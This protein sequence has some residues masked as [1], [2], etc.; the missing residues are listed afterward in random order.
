[1]NVVLTES[2]S[3]WTH[4][5]TFICLCCLRHFQTLKRNLYLIKTLAC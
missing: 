2:I 4:E 5:V 1:M 3:L